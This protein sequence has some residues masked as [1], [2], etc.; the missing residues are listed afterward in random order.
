[1]LKERLLK[2]WK[3]FQKQMTS[4]ELNNILDRGICYSKIEKMHR[5]LVT[6]MNPSFRQGDSA[7][8]NFVCEYEYPGV[9]EGGEDRYFLAFDK[10]FP[11][12]YKQEVT[13]MDL[14]NFRET[15]Q[16]MVWKFCNDPKGLELVAENLRLNQLFMEQVVHPQ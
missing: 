8:E 2:L 9:V 5:I 3:K 15:D 10:L 11:E 13:Y 16:Q 7:R 14:L 4:E 1:M 6:G 12:E